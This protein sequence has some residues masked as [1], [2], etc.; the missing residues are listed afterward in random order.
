MS[1]EASEVVVSLEFFIMPGSYKQ[2]PLVGK[3]TQL[4]IDFR[5]DHLQ[6]AANF[7]LIDRGNALIPVDFFSC[8]HRENHVPA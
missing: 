6:T 7:P 8:N 5:S 3:Q 1:R 2:E 4:L